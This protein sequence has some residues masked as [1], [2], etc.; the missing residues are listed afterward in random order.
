MFILSALSNTGAEV[1]C[2]ASQ[3]LN[4]FTSYVCWCTVF[5]EHVKAKPSSRT[6]KCYRFVSFFVAATVK[7]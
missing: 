2:P 4:H 1:R 5:L 7:F 6:R 3:K